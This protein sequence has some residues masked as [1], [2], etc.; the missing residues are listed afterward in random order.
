MQWNSHPVIPPPWTSKGPLNIVSKNILDSV[1][2][3]SLD[4][5]GR[6]Q[7]VANFEQVIAMCLD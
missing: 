4:I 3:K 1:S 5:T 7:L 6:I 2:K